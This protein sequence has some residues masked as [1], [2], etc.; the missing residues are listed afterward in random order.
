M[1]CLVL[2]FTDERICYE[3]RTE[4]GHTGGPVVVTVM[5]KDK[6]MPVVIA[7]H[8]DADPMVRECNRGQLLWPFLD[9]IDCR[10]TPIMKCVSI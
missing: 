10:K 9:G 1:L 4:D 7:V 5:R 6:T 2:L 3:A 8:S